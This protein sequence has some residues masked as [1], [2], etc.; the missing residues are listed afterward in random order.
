MKLFYFQFAY[1][2]KNFPKLLRYLVF[3]YLLFFYKNVFS[4]EIFDTEKNSSVV[5]NLSTVIVRENENVADLANRYKTG[6]QDLL[7]ANPD[8]HHWSPQKDSKYIIPSQYILPQE[9]YNGI[10]LNLAELRLYYYMPSSDLYENRKVLTYPVGIGRLDWKTPLGETFIKSKVANP[11]WFP[12]K[13]I[14]LEHEERGEILPRVVKAGPDNPLGKYA[15]KLAVDGGYLLHGTNKKHGIGMMVSHGCIRL[16]NEDI[17]TIFFNAA[18]GTR[19]KIINEPIKIGKYKDFL[20]MEVHA[21]NNQEVYSNNQK[22]HLTTDN[23]YKPVTAVMNFLENNP[24]Y[25]ID[26]KKVFEVYESSLGIPKIIGN[27]INSNRDFAEA[28]L[29]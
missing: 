18:K 7:I 12:P 23:I 21:F 24:N 19:V 4:L 25:S 15:L 3:L 17:E 28:N 20:Y 29:K 14:I 6:F 5:G 27:K 11:S 22:N 10:I 13:S 8:A 9:D 16:R 2:L 1:Y 26:W